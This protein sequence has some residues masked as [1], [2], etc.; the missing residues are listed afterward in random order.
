MCGGTTKKTKE[1][2]QKKKTKKK[3]KQS[4]TTKIQITQKI[5]TKFKKNNKN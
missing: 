3:T 5:I 2:S 4:K 1:K